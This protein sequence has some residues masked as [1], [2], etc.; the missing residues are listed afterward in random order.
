MGEQR[1]NKSAS[2]AKELDARIRDANKNLEKISIR[3]KRD[4]LFVRGRN[5]PPKPGDN[6]GQR[7]E[8]GLGVSATVSGLKVAIADLNLSKGLI[9]IERSF[10]HHREDC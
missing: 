3:I 6:E 5:F 7:Y 10:L 4:R 8:I 9:S 2:S 1:G